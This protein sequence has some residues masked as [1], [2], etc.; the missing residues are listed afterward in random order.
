MDTISSMD[1]KAL[2]PGIDGF[3]PRPELVH[4]LAL[5]VESHFPQVRARAKCLLLDDARLLLELHPF[6]FRFRVGDQ[7][8]FPESLK[9]S[10][11]LGLVLLASFSIRAGP[12]LVV[13]DGLYFLLSRR[14]FL[15]RSRCSSGDSSGGG[16]ESRESGPP[17]IVTQDRGRVAL[18]I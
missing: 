15:T 18:V 3:G 11:L 6:Q 1:V 8:V 9:N 13:A 10:S 2:L 16:A 5:A 7:R 14:S 4:A 12:F 17:A